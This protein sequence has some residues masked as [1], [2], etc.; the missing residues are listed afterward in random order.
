MR[1]LRNV[2]L[3]IDSSRETGRGILQGIIRF[4][5]ERAEW[6]IYFQ[7]H[8]IED[9]PPRWLSGWKADGVLAR[10]NSPRDAR[11]LL[12]TGLPVIDVRAATVL[13]QFPRLE[14]DNQAM[15][16]MVVAYF[17]DRGIRRF[18]FCGFPRGLH[19]LFDERLEA[20]VERVRSLGF[21]CD[22]FRPAGKS[23]GSTSWEVELRQLSR[24]VA[25]LH[26]QTGLMACNDDL[27]IK[28][29][30]AC[31]RMQRAVPDEIAVIGVENDH[32]LCNLSTPPLTSVDVNSERIG[33][34]ACGLLDRMMRGRRVPECTRYPPARIVERQS[35]DIL[36]IE[37]PEVVRAIR[38][39][40]NHACKGMSVDELSDGSSI[41]RS[42]LNRRF[43]EILG[44]SPKEEIA[45]VQ[46]TRARELLINSDLSVHEIA[47]SC[48]F[49]DS[50][51]FSKW[52]HQQ[53]GVSPR[54]FRLKTSK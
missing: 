13:P 6:S 22:V 32:F 15:A 50:N 9:A 41:S 35:T 30:D 31:R 11:M 45:R 14:A 34:D 16:E 43:H 5:R 37:D 18:A 23:N 38:H 49:A 17:L 28:V 8:R 36:A 21:P 54:Q 52:F 12:K 48:G 2:V 7:P 26:G 25:K 10:I 3:L 19:R 53:Q 20:F 4:N 51:Y 29:L 24:W 42:S 27:G 44:R 1:R 33:Y 46:L 39:I 47:A 40:R